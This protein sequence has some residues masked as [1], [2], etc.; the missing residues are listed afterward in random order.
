MSIEDNLI[1]QN[2][3]L[4]AQL[5]GENENITVIFCLHAFE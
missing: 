4:R 3:Q 5:T 2:N 1:K